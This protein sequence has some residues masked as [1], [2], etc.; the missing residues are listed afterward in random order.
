MQYPFIH[1]RSQSSYSLSEGALKIE[2]LVNLAKKNNMPAIALTDNN[3]MF[4]ILEFSIACINNSIQPIIGTSINYLD[5]QTKEHPSQL[6]FLVMNEEGYKN[7]LY[8]SSIS[9]TSGN[10]PIGVYHKDLKKYNNGLICYIGGEYNPLLILKHQNKIEEISVFINNFRNM[11]GQDFLFEIQRVQDPKID[12][13]EKEFLEYSQNFTIPIIGSNNIKYENEN[14][15]NAHDVLLCIAQKLTINQTNRKVSNSEIYFKTS[16]QMINIFEDIPEIIENNFR[17]ALKCNY[18]P[19]EILPKL[20]KFSSDQNLSESELL[21]LKSKEGLLLRLQEMNINSPSIYQERLNYELEI[22]NNMGFAGYFLIVAD[23]VNWAKNKEIAVGPGR[24]SGAGSV[25]A[26]SLSITDLDPL[27]YGLLFERFLNPERVSMPDFDIDFCQNRRDEVIEYVNNKYGKECVAHIITFGTLASRAAIRDVGRVLEIPYSEIDQF[28]KLF[29]YNPA[30]PLSLD[31]SINSDKNLKEMV[32]SD[33]RLSNVVDISLKLE[34]LHRHASTHAAGVVIGDSSIINNVPLYKD[35]NTSVNATQFSM[36]YVEKAG[37]IK[38]DFLGLTTLS[39]IQDSIKLIKENHS[40]FDL[41]HIP[42]DDKKTFQQLS[43]GEAIGIFQLESNGMG[44]VLRQLQPDKFEEIIAVVALFRPGPMDHIPS[45]CNRKHGKEKIEYLHPLLEKVLKETYGIIVYQ[46][47]VMQIAQ[48]LSNYTL[49][50]ADLLR[51][52]MGKKIQKEMDAQKNRFIE[53][54]KS[55]KI[56]I[57]EASKIFDLVN[58]FAGYG[59]NKSHAAGYALLAYQTAYLKTNFPYE[60]MTATFNYS[61]DRTDRII[62]LNKELSSL[63]IEF[64]KP[65]VNHSQAK[66]S[67]EENNGLKSIRFGLGAIKGVGIKSMSNLVKER[68][69][70]GKFIDI[71]DF[72]NRLKGD[73][74]NKRQ[75]EKLVQAGSFDSIETN[76]AKLFY[77][78]PKFVEIYGGSNFKDQNQ[79]MLFEEN[80]LSFDDSNLFDQQIDDWSSG[81]L[82]KNELEVIGFYFSSHPV[83][84]Y[85]KNYFRRNNIIEWNQIKLNEDIKSAKI[86]GSILDIKERS[87][88]EGRKYAFLTVSTLESQIELT[89]FSDKLNDFRNLIKEGNLLLF[90][91]DISRDIENMRLIIRK[92]EDFEQTFSNQKKIINIYLQ[93][94][95]EI[96][97]LE[98]LFKKS[99]RKNEKLYLY[100][101]KDNKLIS[102]DFSDKFEVISYKY[103]DKLLDAKKIDYSLEIV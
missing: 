84:L 55:N 21:N 81:F 49:G 87:N 26:W 48:V 98:K 103:L 95:F 90:H 7:L 79:A 32:A 101:D 39:I 72:M 76:R 11:F 75:L 63:N 60:F 78:V 61:I 18:Y 15:Y 12:G 97:L 67:I 34:G 40:N 24:G 94:Y 54:A 8:L 45:F 80:K 92:I 58:K 41:K 77:N 10:N 88:K 70:N 27:Q 20:P 33:E 85:P 44:S 1:L 91:I 31:E 102:F 30:N 56:S 28:A 59:F 14:D 6:N 2:K 52:A 46:E 83:S 9:H 35:P 36:K 50:E 3:N 42:M 86:V 5:I 62:L 13:F 96:D 43:K 64:K 71:I 69:N 65:D 89:I 23:F 73:V 17:I 47:Q 37:L 53:G 99:N 29:P 66:F 38:F 4:G 82:L 57:N 22:I 51:R 68:E 25:V 100:I 16:E 93:Q 19:K 74:I